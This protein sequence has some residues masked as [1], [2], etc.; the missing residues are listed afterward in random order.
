[1]KKVSLILF[2]LLLSLLSIGAQNK[3]PQGL[4][5]LQRLAYEDGRPDIVADMLQYKFFSDFVPVTILVMNNSPELCAYW[6]KQDEPHPYLFT[7]DVPVGNDGRGTR[8]FN[9]DDNHVAVKWFNTIRPGDE[10]RFPMN[11][12]ITEYYDRYNIEPEIETA[13]TMLQMKNVATS[14]RLGGCW[15]LKGIYNDAIEELNTNNMQGDVYKIYGEKKLTT[16]VCHG[17][18]IMGSN[19]FICPV[20]YKSES[21]VKEATNPEGVITWKDDNT[22]IFKTIAGNGKV[23]EELWERSKLPE[24][25]QRLFAPKLPTA[26]M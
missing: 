8:I 19:I 1:M 25:F 9:C 2:S 22:F 23:I 10:E 15:K 7:G 20:E 18:R 12:F 16:L 4:Y 24:S 17:N 21:V 11:Q 14:Q 6:V 13:I 3:N 26:P 5:K